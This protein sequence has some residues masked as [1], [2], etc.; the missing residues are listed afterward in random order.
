MQTFGIGHIYQG[1][2]VAGVAI[3]LSYWTLQAINAVLAFVLI[4]L[5]TAPL[6]WL[7]FMVFSSL[8]VAGEALERR[9]PKGYLAG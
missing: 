8:D 9:K 1:R 4:G 2:P 5:V 7:L 3:M 6:T